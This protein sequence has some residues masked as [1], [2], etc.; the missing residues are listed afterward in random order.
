MLQGGVGTA[1]LSVGADGSWSTVDAF[2]IS[3]GP[4]KA[5][6]VADCTEIPPSGP[7]IELATYKLKHAAVNLP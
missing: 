3:G 5:K 2:S 1:P 7:P 4:Y 6:V